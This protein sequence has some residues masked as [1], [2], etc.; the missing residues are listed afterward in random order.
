MYSEFEE[1][2]LF[3]YYALLNGCL[4]ALLWCVGPY[5]DETREYG[6]CR[7]GLAVVTRRILGAWLLVRAA[8]RGG[9]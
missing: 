5:V 2:N 3:A 9:V 6:R 8:Y 7:R 4:D 1:G